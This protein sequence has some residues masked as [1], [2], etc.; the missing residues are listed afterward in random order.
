MKPNTR[1]R[2][3]GG[4]CTGRESPWIPMGTPIAVR[5]A[6][7]GIVGPTNGPLLPRPSTLTIFP[8]H[9]DLFVRPIRD[10]RHPQLSKLPDRIMQ[11]DISDVG[12]IRIQDQ[13]IEKNCSIKECLLVYVIR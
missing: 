5:Q 4:V 13:V 1:T 8:F 2:S 12:C 9:A 7:A 6:W 10:R 11:F 3:T